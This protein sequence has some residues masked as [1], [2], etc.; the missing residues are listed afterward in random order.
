[1]KITFKKRLILISTISVLIPLLIFALT[2]YMMGSRLFINEF[3]QRS[4]ENLY[5][6][7][8]AVNLYIEKIKHT[9]NTISNIPAMHHL[10]T[11]DLLNYKNYSEWTEMAPYKSSEAEKEIY[12]YL[13]L[14]HI[15]NP[16]LGAVY[17]GTDSGGFTMHPTSH[18]RPF[19]DPSKRPWFKEASKMQGQLTITS[20]FKSSDK[21]YNIFAVAKQIYFPKN[22]EYGVV[23]VNIELD[24]I[25]NI[26][27]QLNIG[28][29]GFV[30]LTKKDNT[31]LANP[32]DP[33]I[34]FKNL[35]SHEI[36]KSY[37]QLTQLGN[38]WD[39]ITI[40]KKKYIAKKYYSV[41]TDWLFYFLITESELL[42]PLK[43]MLTFII[44]FSIL[45]I[46]LFTPLAV[47]SVVKSLVPLE[48]LNKHLLNLSRGNADLNKRISIYSND[49]VGETIE[50]F[51][52]LSEKL[53]NL[54]IDMKNTTDTISVSISEYST[55]MLLA[56]TEIEKTKAA[57]INS[58]GILIKITELVSRAQEDSSLFTGKSGKLKLEKLFTNLS[59]CFEELKDNMEDIKSSHIGI[60]NSIETSINHCRD[61]KIMLKDIRKKIST[62]KTRPAAE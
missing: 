57:V 49:E 56:S 55:D 18:R 32:A 8:Q 27:E 19:Y 52:L 23:S 54:F 43:K 60:N 9:V 29:T 37:N 1:M 62:Y 5:L 50:N 11:D 61:N 25:T 58:D 35:S 17:I 42:Q 46:S 44:V 15:N 16:D 47:L 21:N 4:I 26:I 48:K 24:T 34:N 3:K 38:N 12:E 13:K 2:F 41:G 39:E 20:P 22:K 6:V 51:N 45:I 14:V 53:N 33:S 31:I 36:D 59:E 7:D 30:I 28:K 40:N 10:N